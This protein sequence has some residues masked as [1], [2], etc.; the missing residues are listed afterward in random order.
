MSY[1]VRVNLTVIICLSF[2]SLFAIFFPFN[3]E[4]GVFYGFVVLF[5]LVGSYLLFLLFGLSFLSQLKGFGSVNLKSQSKFSVYWMPLLLGFIGI[6]LILVDRILFRGINPFI[7]SPAEMRNLMSQG[8]GGVSSAFSLFGNV[9]QCFCII[10]AYYMISR[11]KYSFI[12]FSL[13]FMISVSSAYLLGGRTP[14]LCFVVICFSAWIY[15]SKYKFSFLN[16]LYGFLG[17]VLLVFFGVYVFVL[18]AELSN[19]DSYVYSTKLMLH[20]GFDDDF[21]ALSSS[22]GIG[23][24]WNFLML[25]V[26][27]LVHPFFITSDAVV[28]GT[29]SGNVSFY[30]L[31]FLGS[32][33]FPIDLSSFKHDYYELFLSL[34]GGLYYDFGV[35]GLFFG[36][37]TLAVIYVFGALLSSLL[38][39]RADF[40]FII[41]LFVISTLLLSPLLSSI[42]F[43]FFN[44]YIFILFSYFSLVFVFN[45]YFEV[46]R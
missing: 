16:I 18:R 8:D 26:G 15:F 17:M 11:R 9:L 43:V 14:I 19:L 33:L 22:G 23:D 31:L 4:F 25:V 34:P 24:Y 36:G 10:P 21:S 45:E 32:K 1:D 6:G 44:F 3:G 5:I 41:I 2:Y 35:F 42:N 40:P 37:L 13:A 28:N 12:I 30:A 20:L 29:G 7:L 39:G 27:Y 46:S 38:K